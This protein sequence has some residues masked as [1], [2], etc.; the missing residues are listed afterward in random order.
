MKVDTAITGGGLAALVCGIRLQRSGR[1]TVI[2]SAGQNCLF[3]FSGAFGFLSRL[4]DG[5]AVE[6]PFEVLSSLPDRH[7]YSLIGPER[8]K[9]YAAEVRPFFRS[10]GAE[11][12]GC[13][14]SNMWR[15]LST[16]ATKMAWASLTETALFSENRPLTNRK[17]LIINIPGFLDFFPKSIA[18]SL[19]KSGS[20]CRTEDV[21]VP[22]TEALR[23][24]S[25]VVRSLSLAK[26]FEQNDVLEKFIGEV[27]KS[28]KDED[29]IILPQLFG[30]R[31]E[32]ALAYI[33]SAIPAEVLFFGTMTPSIP[34]NR[35]F[36]QLKTAYEEAGGCF[37]S[38]SVRSASVVSGAVSCIYTDALDEP[39]EAD[40]FVLATGS[41]VSKGLI[42]SPDSVSEPVF[43]LDVE[44][45][46]DR[47]EWYCPDAGAKQNYLGYGVVTDRCFH[48]SINGM[49]VR[50]LYAAGSVLAGSNPLY[51]GSGAGTAIFTAMR[52]SDLILER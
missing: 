48:P 51:E 25:S 24:S 17:V 31:S 45:G 46:A 9:R 47:S 50:N 27:R 38:G 22:E 12:N 37:I 21:S 15:Y 4:P 16:G 36:S 34:G 13:D 10:C 26:I 35:L 30:L 1:K 49:P 52:V 20:K 40:D 42:S 11:L 23:M 5:T 43:G 3:F 29:A 8:M 6:K 19:E 39:V 44:A 14:E 41:F 7:P 18:R 28:I 33:R 32:D 2:L